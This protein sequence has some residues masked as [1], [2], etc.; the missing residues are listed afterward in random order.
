M[1]DISITFPG[2][3]ALDSVSFRMFPG[4]LRSLVDGWSRT[5]SGG[6]RRARL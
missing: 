3:K 5:L 6:A 2:V 4:G 1:T